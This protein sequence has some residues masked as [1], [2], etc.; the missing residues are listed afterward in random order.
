MGHKSTPVNLVT[1][2]CC[3]NNRVLFVNHE[4]M[5]TRRCTF[6]SVWWCK[7]ELLDT[8][9]IFFCR[10]KWEN[11]WKSMQCMHQAHLTAIRG[12]AVLAIFS[13]RYWAGQILGKQGCW[14]QVF[15][16]RNMIETKVPCLKLRE[17]APKDRFVASDEHLR[18]WVKGRVPHPA[19]PG[20]PRIDYFRPPEFCQKLAPNIAFKRTYPFLRMTWLGCGSIFSCELSNIIVFVGVSRSNL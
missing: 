19:S 1:Q 3:Q 10:I 4:G 9:N 11:G 17:L 15:T 2:D 6:E 7:V 16:A 12:C 20:K 13:A 5:M 8:W 14:G 18:P